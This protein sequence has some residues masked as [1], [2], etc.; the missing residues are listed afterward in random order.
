MPQLLP[1]FFVNMLSYSFLLFIVILYVL[2]TY[3]LPTYPLLFNVRMALT[4][5]PPLFNYK[6]LLNNISYPDQIKRIYKI[7]IESS[8]S[9]SY[10]T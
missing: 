2:S 6:D 9:R 8:H 5:T 10:S 4:N 3:I 7:K 1:F